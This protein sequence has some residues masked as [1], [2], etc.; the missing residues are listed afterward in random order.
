MVSQTNSNKHKKRLIPTLL[1]F[2]QK[3]EDEETFPKTFYKTTVIMIP[4]S[5]KDNIKTK[6]NKT[7]LQAYIFDEYRC[8]KKSQ[9]NISKI[10]PIMHTKDH[11]PCPSVIHTKFTWM[12]QLIQHRLKKKQKMC[13]ICNRCRTSL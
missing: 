8:K 10:N 13:D 7:K 6:Q 11:I 2:L 12:V 3:I 1:K 9:Q 4:K 5:E